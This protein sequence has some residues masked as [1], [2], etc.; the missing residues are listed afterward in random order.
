M[1]KNL[2]K[3]LL[4]SFESITDLITVIFLHRNSRRHRRQEASDCERDS[5]QLRQDRGRAPRREPGRQV[6]SI[7]RACKGEV[8]L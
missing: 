3:P 7:E 4:F 2:N 1:L 5:R 6:E 8:L